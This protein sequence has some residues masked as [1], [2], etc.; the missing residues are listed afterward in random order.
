MNVLK[1]EQLKIIY[2][3]TLPMVIGLFSIMA[4]QLVDSLFI[5]QLGAKPLAVIG[6][7]I[8]IYQLI[9]GIQVGIGIATTACISNALGEGQYRYANVLGTFVLVVG[10]I[11]ITLLC[12]LLW[13]FQDAILQSLGADPSILK[14][15][16][17]YWF[18]WLISCWLG[19]LLYFGY[20]ICRSHGETMIPGKVMVIASV[21]NVVLDPIFIFTLDMGLAGAA[22]ATCVSF[23]VGFFIT[24]RTVLN[25][26]FISIP[27]NLTRVEEGIRSIIQFAIPAA[28]S[29][30]LPPLSAMLVTLIVASYGE[31][32]IAAWGLA[33]RIEY[34][35]IIV[36]LALT[37]SLPPLIGRLK[38][39]KEIEEIVKLVKVAVGLVIVVQVVLSAFIMMLSEPITGL[40]TKDADIASYLH[41]Y[42]WLVPISYGALGVCMICVS[43]CNAMGVPKPALT[44]SLLRLFG[45]YFPSIWIGSELFG[46]WGIYLGASVG[47]I[48]SG[49]VGWSIFVYHYNKLHRNHIESTC[50]AN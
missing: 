8:P 41:Y 16:R 35:V 47:N 27:K 3:Q 26:Y 45:C 24:F 21:L 49:V 37:M 18:P 30:F 32:A 20:S 29:Q 6:F 28:L 43:A 5:S 4:S 19:A 10:F 50:H 2:Q 13:C 48:L 14:L 42:L 15:S 46:L 31:L 44:A 40:L 23:V 36:I 11:T 1:S 39:Q 25:R 34:I 38:G 9:I 12:L 33:N 7:S 17:Q 22:W